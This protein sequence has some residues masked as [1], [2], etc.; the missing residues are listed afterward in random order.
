MRKGDLINLVSKDTKLSKEDVSKVVESAFK[1]IQEHV[2]KPNEGFYYRGFGSLVNKP[3]AA[4][5]GR[6]I[7]TSEV[8]S[9]SAGRKV[10][11]IPSKSGWNNGRD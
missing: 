6:N 11:F 5:K 1:S 10:K 2:N 3:T 4:R 8:I 9:I 7:K